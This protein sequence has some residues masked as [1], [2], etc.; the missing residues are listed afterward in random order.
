M[1]DNGIW[2]IQSVLNRQTIYESKFDGDITRAVKPF[3]LELKRDGS[4]G[5]YDSAGENY[6]T[7][8]ISKMGGIMAQITNEGEFVVLTMDGRTRVWSSKSG[9]DPTAMRTNFIEICPPLIVP[10][11]LLAT[12]RRPSL[13]GRWES[14]ESEGELNEAT[15]PSEEENKET[16]VVVVDAPVP[17]SAPAPTEEMPSMPPQESDVAKAASELDSEADLDEAEEVN[18]EVEEESNEEAGEEESSEAEV[19]DA[20]EGASELDDAMENE[21]EGEAEVDSAL[22]N[23]RRMHRQRRNRVNVRVNVKA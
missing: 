23:A 13:F 2:S 18:E 21:A 12:A 17:A 3:K 10:G 5:V 8:G 6:W 22:S 20:L 16:P 7:P 11:S 15:Q 1:G 4:L 19:D 9:A 14:E